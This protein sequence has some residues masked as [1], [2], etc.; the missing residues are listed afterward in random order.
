VYFSDQLHYGTLTVAVGKQALDKKLK[1]IGIDVLDENHFTWEAFKTICNKNRQKTFVDLL[2]NQKHICGIGNYLKSEIL[3]DS[4]ASIASPIC[5]YTEDQLL[6]VYQSCKSITRRCTFGKYRLQVYGRRRDPDGHQVF[7]VK[8]SDKRTTHWV[9]KVMPLKIE[10][11]CSA[12]RQARLASMP[13]ATAEQ[14]LGQPATDPDGSGSNAPE[15][16]DDLYSVS[17][18]ED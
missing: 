11:T 13:A 2:M 1:T 16:A 12:S 3:Y 18:A 5:D 6:R 8:T 9:P 7:R 14:T 17:S 4:R 15:F 10:D